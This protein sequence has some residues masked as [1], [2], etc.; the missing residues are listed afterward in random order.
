MQRPRI[1]TYFAS[2]GIEVYYNTLGHTEDLVRAYVSQFQT[3]VDN[4][5]RKKSQDVK[6]S[7]YKELYPIEAREKLTGFENIRQKDLAFR[8]KVSKNIIQSQFSPLLSVEPADNNIFPVGSYKTVL[9]NLLKKVENPILYLSGGMDSELVGWALCELG[10]DFKTVIFEWLDN[11]GTVLNSRDVRY[12]YNFC[13]LRGLVPIIKQVNVEELW[14]SEHFVK[15]A[16]DTQIQSTHLMTHAYAI[17]LISSQYKDHTHLF[18]GEVRYY[19]NSTDRQGKPVN[20]VYLDKLV[21]AVGTG[22]YE[23]LGRFNGVGPAPQA[24]SGWDVELED[25]GLN[26][27]YPGTWRISGQWGPYPGP[28]NFTGTTGTFTVGSPPNTGEGS[29][30]WLEAPRGSAPS[31]SARNVGPVYTPTGL[32]NLSSLAPESWTPITSSTLIANV[33]AYDP[34]TDDELISARLQTTIEIAV[35]GFTTPNVSFS[36]D[37]T[38]KAIIVTPL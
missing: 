16:I 11:S 38:A 9:L 37:L 4:S 10:K 25:T 15:F 7:C 13:K 34:S 29:G 12:A 36:L 32:G 35:T 14:A 27:G 31:Y 19:S 2:K 17:D 28:G 23:A 3:E 20:I 5:Y 6:Y 22:V 26:I 8:V 33:L 1:D 18:G 24:S 30:P 21:P